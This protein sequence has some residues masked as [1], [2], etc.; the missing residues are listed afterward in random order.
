MG[1]RAGREGFQGPGRPKFGDLCGWATDERAN[2]C[3]KGGI[4]WALRLGSLIIGSGRL[5]LSDHRSAARVPPCRAGV[6]SA[7]TTPA[8]TAPRTRLY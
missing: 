8:S 4:R 6:P 3:L 7:T 2:T 5:T 1:S